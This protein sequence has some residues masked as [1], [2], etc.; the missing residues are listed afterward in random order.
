MAKKKKK[1]AKKATK[2]TESKRGKWGKGKTPSRI[3]AGARR[4]KR[5]PEDPDD[6]HPEFLAAIR[7]TGLVEESIE[8]VGVGRTT[9]F[10]HYRAGGDFA[11]EVDRIKEAHRH[12]QGMALADGAMQRALK[13]ELREEQ[14][15]DANG[16]PFTKTIRTW[17]PHRERFMLEKYVPNIFGPPEETETDTAADIAESIRLSLQAMGATVAGPAENKTGPEE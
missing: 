10:D 16:M 13:G 14:G 4:G 17:S 3:P 8:A 6:W 15:T 11:K 9:Y 2:K 1:A 5:T 7:V 12:F